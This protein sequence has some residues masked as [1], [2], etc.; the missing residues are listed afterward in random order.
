MACAA[1]AHNAASCHRHRRLRLRLRLQLRLS[2]LDDGGAIFNS[3][4]FLFTQINSIGV[5]S[6]LCAA[7]YAK[8]SSRQG[9]GVAGGWSRSRSG[10]RRRRQPHPPRTFAKL[11]QCR[12]FLSHVY[13]KFNACT[14][15]IL[16]SVAQWDEC[17]DLWQ[18]CAVKTQHKIEQ[19][20]ALLCP[21]APLCVTALDSATHRLFGSSQLAHICLS[22][23]RAVLPGQAASLPGS[24]CMWQ[25]REAAASVQCAIDLRLFDCI[26]T[27]TLA[28]TDADSCGC[29][30]RLKLHAAVR[31]PPPPCSCHPS[32]PPVDWLVPAISQK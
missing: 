4:T 32:L 17:H 15:H 9:G 26:R 2:T 13:K 31:H 23:C 1:I 27:R 19:S 21:L 14:F 18:V 16:C 25:Q 10:R 7:T 12:K 24:C 29:T 6:A 22:I 30:L 8:S 3:F 20:F 28:A 5:S 11:L